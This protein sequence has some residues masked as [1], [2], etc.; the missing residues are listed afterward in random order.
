MEEEEVVTAIEDAAERSTAPSEAV[1]SRT[2]G[3]DTIYLR[4]IVL[5]IRSQRG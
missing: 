1:Y 5:R 3:A 4:V 2:H